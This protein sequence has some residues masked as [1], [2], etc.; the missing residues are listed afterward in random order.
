MAPATEAD[1]NFDTHEWKSE[2]ASTRSG[3]NSPNIFAKVRRKLLLT[4]PVRNARSPRLTEEELDALTG[5]LP[6]ATNYTYAYS[7]I[8]DPSLPDHWEVPNLGGTTSGS[9]SEQ[10]HWSAA[11][12]SRQ[13]LYILRFPV[14]LVLHVITYIL[15]AFYHVIKITSFTIWD[16]LL[17]LVKLA[18][19][20]YYA[21]QDHR[22]RTAL[23]RNRQEPFSTKAARSIRRF[24]EILVYVVLTPYRMLTRSNNGVEQ[25]QYR[26]IKDQLENERASRMTTRSQTLE[27]S[28]KFD[29]LSKS[30]ARRAAPAFVKTSTITRITAKVFSSSPFGEGTSENITPTVVTTRTVKQR[31][32]TPRFRQTRATREAITRALDTP[33]LEIDTPLSTYGLR[34]RGLSHLNTPEPTFDIGHAAATSTP[35][36][37]QETYNYQYEEATGNKIKTAFTWLGYL[38]LFPFFAARHVWYTF[39]DYG[40]SAYMKLTNYQQAPMETIHVRDINEPAP[41]SSDVHD[42]VGVSWRIRIADFLS[43]F[44]ATIVEAH[45]VVFA[46]FKGGIVE[47][48]SYFGG[49]FAG[50]TDKKSSKFSWCQILGLLLAL[51]FAIFL[52]GFLTS[53]NTAIRVKEITK[54]KN[55]SKKS[56]GSLPAVPIWISAANHVK[57]YTWMVKEFVVDIAFDTYNYGKSTIGRLGTT[58]RYAW[59]LIASGCGAV[60][61]GLKSVLSS[62]FRFIDFCAGKLF[63][64]GS[65]GFLSA[66][67]SIGTFF[68]GCYE[69]L[70]NGCT[71]IVGH[72]KSFIYNAS[73]AVY[74][75]FSTIFAGL[76]NFSTSSQNSI[77]SLLKSFGTG[78]TNIFY[79][80][81]YAPIAGVFNFAGDNYMY[82][83]NEVAAVFGKVYNS[84]VSVLK[85]VINWIL[86]LIAYPFSLC[87]R[88]WIRISQYA[89]EDVVQVIPIPQAITPTPDVE[90]IVEEPLRKV[91]DVEDEELVIIPAPA[92]KPIPV[93]AP[94]PAPVIIHQTNVVE[95]VD[96]DAIIKEVTEKVT[97]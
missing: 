68:N 18:K 27:R 9:L 2:F 89:P 15:E 49:L 97:N 12:L 53:D 88:A 17:Y 40:K 94:T 11:S 61:N 48:V 57:H 30:P 4:P 71:A 3:R 26:S 23:I 72:T 31:S 52:L 37:P 13:L 54:D 16:Y 39:Y 84:V 83:F 28:R 19:T 80:F 82:F 93:P 43:S 87:T 34:S 24:F 29:G 7:K 90:R 20:R 46:M 78:I 86:F 38:I 6:Y 75:F 66:N 74:N 50:L 10:E 67:K 51:L 64:Y 47:T 35:L 56:E 70:Y 69:T 25:Y 63:Y 42:A 5:D 14:Y 85:T 45:Q 22:R 95:T 44:V 73:N 32:V 36:F 33:E 65:D 1:N 58:P 55:A 62:S 60:G 77:L 59:D 96:K 92:P 76:L 8:Y 21:Y 91:T 81:I 79:N 41:S